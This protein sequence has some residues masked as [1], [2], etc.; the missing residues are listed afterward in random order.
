[1]VAGMAKRSD[2][3]RERRLEPG[4][5]K[6]VPDGVQLLVELAVQHAGHGDLYRRHLHLRHDP[7][8]ISHPAV[9]PL[10]TNAALQ[11]Q[12]IR[13]AGVE[14]IVSRLNR[15]DGVAAGASETIAGNKPA[16]GKQITISLRRLGQR[17]RVSA[18]RSGRYAVGIN[19]M[20]HE[21]LQVVVG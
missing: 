17:G 14:R 8:R 19:Q 2:R 1:M 6:D 13:S 20:V 12:E 4:E 3:I 11:S 18:P 10:P 21:S 16:T 9:E 5:I 15:A 7:C